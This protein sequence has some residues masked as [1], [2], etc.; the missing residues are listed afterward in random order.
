MKFPS[1]LN[2]DGKIVSEMGP[3]TNT[4]LQSI[5][6]WEQTSITFRSGLNELTYEW[7]IG[8]LNLWMPPEGPILDMFISYCVYISISPSYCG[9]FAMIMS[10]IFVFL[11]V[12]IKYCNMYANQCVVFFSDIEI[13]IHSFVVGKFRKQN[14][15]I[16]SQMFWIINSLRAGPQ[17]NIKM[18]S[19]QYRNPIVEIRWS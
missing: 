13:C 11:S 19:Y 17:F 6:P 14:I 12:I 3:W 18:P 16:S 5:G 2:C 9:L 1:N 10:C 7:N 8:H 4:D 15:M